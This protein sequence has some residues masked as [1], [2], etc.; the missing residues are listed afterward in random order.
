[1]YT[2]KARVA[3]TALVGRK[4]PVSKALNFILFQVCW[5]ACVLGA[6]NNLLWLG[7]VAVAASLLYQLW[8]IDSWK[9]ELSLALTV[10][11][12][13]TALD[14]IPFSMGAF[15]FTTA[16]VPWGYPL[17]MSALWVGFATTFHSSLSWIKKRYILSA[18]FGAI[19]GPLSY[20]AGESL[21]AITLSA[22]R[23]FALTAIS[24][25]WAIVTP[26]LFYKGNRFFTPQAGE[27]E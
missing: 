16:S 26:L 27:M 11:I 25:T 14:Y 18:A 7:P 9:R 6:A 12:F 22:D 5:F 1:M 4:G 20:I 3:E 2:E 13:G 15:S 24:T 23:V 21:G 8:R 17:W 10:G 19:G